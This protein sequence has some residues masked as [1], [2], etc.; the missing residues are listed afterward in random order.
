M[1]AGYTCPAT[2]HVQPG[3]TSTH[4]GTSVPQGVTP[5]CMEVH[6]GGKTGAEALR[7]GKEGMTKQHVFSMSSAY[8]PRQQKRVEDRFGRRAGISIPVTPERRT[9]SAPRCLPTTRV[10]PQC[11]PTAPGN[12]APACTPP[13]C[14]PSGGQSTVQE[15]PGRRQLAR[16]AHGGRGPESAGTGWQTP[17]EH[18]RSSNCLHIILIKATPWTAGDASALTMRQPVS[19]RHCAIPAQSSASRGPYSSA[20]MDSTGDKSKTGSTSLVS[21]GARVSASAIAQVALCVSDDKQ[22]VIKAQYE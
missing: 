5:T 7:R 2:P 17:G 8:W 6:G 4:R 10:N 3:L 15:G 13:S 11:L 16:Q 14:C 19:A 1:T 21:G 22:L 12:P 18:S 9:P 20:C